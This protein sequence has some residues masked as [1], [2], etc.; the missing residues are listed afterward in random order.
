LKTEYNQTGKNLRKKK[1]FCKNINNREEQKLL[2]TKS[3]SETKKYNQI[4][5]NIHQ[6]RTSKNKVTL[7][8]KKYLAE[9]KRMSEKKIKLRR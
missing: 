1:K 9:T 3:A 8:K 2:K 6:K 5:L 7:S 4:R